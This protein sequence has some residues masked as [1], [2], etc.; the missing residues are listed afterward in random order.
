MK[1]YTEKI[2]L[3]TSDEVPHFN[4]ITDSV[5]KI[6]DSSGI[7]EGTVL[8]FSQHTTAAIVIQE[9]EDGIF[10]D[11]K[12]TLELVASKTKEYQHHIVAKEIPDEPLNGYAHCH[13]VFIGP[14]EIV[15]ISE[16]KMMLGTYQHIYLIELDRARPRTVV[17]QVSGEVS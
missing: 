4:N 10:K 1:F 8:I 2:S 17:V 3:E 12:D 9:N 11:V 7:K 14:S 13:H 5:K 6:V 16:G 15:P